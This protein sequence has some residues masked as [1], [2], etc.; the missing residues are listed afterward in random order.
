VSILR[1]FA[2]HN[3]GIC[4]LV[5]KQIGQNLNGVFFDGMVE[6]CQAIDRAQSKFGRADTV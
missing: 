5:D 4:L 6:E 2:A 3:V 1:R